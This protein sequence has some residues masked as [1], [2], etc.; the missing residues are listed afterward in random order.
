MQQ[1]ELSATDKAGIQQT[2]QRFSQSVVAGNWQPLQA[3]AIPSLAGDFNGVSFAIADMAPKVAGAHSTTDFLYLLDA[4]DAKQTLS[5][6]QFFCGLFNAP[7]HV[8]FGIPNLPPGKYAFAIS[9]IEGGKSPYKISYVLQNVAGAWKLAG[10]FPKP[11]EAAGHDGVYYWKQARAAKSQGQTHN[12]YFDYMTANDLLAPVPF[13]SSPN[14]DKLLSEQQA[15][16]PSDIPVDKPV[17]LTLGGKSYQFTQMFPVSTDKGMALVV[18]YS[19]PDVSD[20]TAA[21]Q[22]NMNIIKSLVEK[23]PE[24]KTN[25]AEIVARATPPAGADYGTE[26]EIKDIK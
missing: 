11:K 18:K 7:V 17:E 2:A 22:D 12:A 4:T 15:V 3:D 6:A 26:L 21:F 19:V 23:Y 14:L 25:F 13:A 1:S 20:T 16:Q 9:E 10:F 5:Q 24:Y 8:T